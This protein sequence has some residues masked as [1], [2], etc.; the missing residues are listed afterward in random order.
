MLVSEKEEESVEK[1]VEENI[2]LA[3]D[4]YKETHWRQYPE[5]TG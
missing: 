3:T 1:G 4:A 5:D 2:I